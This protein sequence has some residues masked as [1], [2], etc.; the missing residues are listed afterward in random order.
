MSYNSSTGIISA[1]VSIDDVKSALGESSNDVATLCT[2]SN[3]NMWAKYK[4]T[5][6]PAPFPED[7]YKAGDGNYGMNIPNDARVTNTNALVAKYSLEHNGYGGMYKRP[8]GGSTSPYRLGDFRGY[9]HD[10]NPE[11]KSIMGIN[12]FVTGTGDYNFT[13]EY[14]AIT[15]TGDQISYSQFKDFKDCYFG[16]VIYTSGGNFYTIVTAAK[17]VSENN[18]TCR[19]ASNKLAVG[20]YIAYPMFCSVDYSASDTL[21]SM[22]MYA[23]P[24]LSPAN[25]SVIS[26]SSA[27]YAKYAQITAK[28]G[29]D[30]TSI[31]VTLK[32]KSEVTNVVVYCVY[33]TDPSKGGSFVEGETYKRIDRIGANE[34]KFASFVNLKSG[35]NWKIY[36]YSGSSY[37]V[38]G[39]LPLGTMSEM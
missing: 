7:W 21:K 9:R 5:S 13:V 37:I 17:P 31:T 34:T 38:K 3:I 22:Y 18:Y 23:V 2:S 27:E 35:K 19:L 39:L 26:S 10:A 30:K 1:P 12:V 20:E 24:N 28:Y 16:Y 4:P 29:V 32:T 14:N 33:Q 6:Y 15:E 25:F 11:I 36:V 8:T